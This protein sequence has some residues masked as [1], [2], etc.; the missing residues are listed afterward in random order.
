MLNAYKGVWS[1]RYP[2]APE[3]WYYYPAK[4]LG[5]DMIEFQREI[6]LWKALWVTFHRFGTGGGVVFPGV[7]NPATGSRSTFTRISESRYLSRTETAIGDRKYFSA[8]VFDKEDPSWVVEYP[9]KDAGDVLGYLD[10]SL[11]PDVVYDFAPAIEAHRAVGA[12]Y[13]LEMWLGVPFFD[14]IAGA[15]GFEQAIMYFYA[16]DQIESYCIGCSS[17]CNSLLGPRLW[18][19]WDKPYIRAMAGE[20]RLIIGT[21]DQVGKETPEDNIIYA[22]IDEARA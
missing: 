11:S 1:D 19:K 22:M 18:R 14:L 12:D 15:M 5:V 6:S 8:R 2:V 9:V 21:G 20:P 10:G 7:S 13:L 16:E 4:V 3:F 17:S